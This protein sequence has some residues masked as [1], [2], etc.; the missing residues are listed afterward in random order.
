MARWRQGLID[1]GEDR[2]RPM[3]SSA[4]HPLNGIDF[5]EYTRTPGTRQ[6]T[7]TFVKARPAAPPLEKSHFSI[8][9]GIRVTG[10]EVESILL[11]AA[12][13]QQV[14]LMLSAEGDFSTY[15]VRVEHPE[16]DEQLSEASFGFKAACPSPF[17][18]RE[19]CNCG[20]VPAEEPALDYLARDYQ[21]FRRMLL[22]F[23]SARNPNWTERLPSDLGV[24]LVELFAY[25]GDYLSYFQD[26]AATEAYLDTALHRVSV[27]RHTRLIDYR[28]HDGGNAR[29]FVHLNCIAAGTVDAG[30]RMC[31][32]IDRPLVGSTG[33][34]GNVIRPDSGFSTD[35]AFSEVVLFE[36]ETDLAVLPEHNEL[37]IHTFGNA[38]CCIGAGTTELY[39]FHL[40]A[41]GRAVR[42]SLGPADLL[43]LEEVRSPRTGEPVDANPSNRWV[44]K[45]VE[46]SD[47]TDE[48]LTDL[49]A[50]RLNIADAALPLLR[51]EWSVSEA[52]PEAIQVSAVGSDLLPIDP[53]TVARGNIVAAD[54]GLTISLDSGRD[55]LG[56]PAEGGG[57]YPIAT[58]GVP[59]APV[60]HT[61]NGPAVELVL[62]F[63]GQEDETWSTVSDLLDSTPYDQHFVTE[64]DD[65]GTPNLRFGDDIYG[66]M[67][68]E[69]ERAQLTM[70]IGNG[71]AGNIGG[72]SLVHIAT[73]AGLVDA[74][75]QPLAAK[76]GTDPQP[77]AEVRR[78]APA[79]FRAEQ[80]RAVTEDDWRNAA[81][82]H[83]EVL[84][85]RA[86]FRWTGSWH[87]IFVAI[88][89][90]DSRNLLPTAGGGFALEVGFARRIH[91]HL[92]RFKLAGYDLATRSAV[93]VPIEIAATLCVARG[94]FPG[95]VMAAVR[96][97]LEGFFDQ[98]H[99]AFGR[100]V[101]LSQI[102]AAIRPIEG[103]ES[104]T[105]TTF[106][107]YWEPD[108][109][110][111][112]R[113][114]IDIDAFEI[115]RLDNNPSAPE[116]GVLILETA[117][118]R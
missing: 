67:P 51:V 34:P 45:L 85:A 93:Y 39:L 21:S 20:A 110:S 36:T 58:L 33:L 53:V 115:A 17:D 52:L 66:R 80:F 74:I 30:T 54:H 113:G 22:D 18:C 71:V 38:E 25:A 117:G 89:P 46:T 4:A 13:P 100:P 118:A 82:R 9:G 107:R 70:R 12:A 83:P 99:A 41:D 1:C 65:D 111:L 6:L 76:G 86:I 7:I 42:P 8:S 32:R 24:T 109:G 87:T 10:I 63:A 84:D 61:A 15:V 44:V 112:D 23:V 90:R 3:L 98:D 104:A 108:R 94:Y 19:D 79:A 97:V 49:L 78:L 57:R 81:L 101:Y 64:V 75:Y 59:A 2:R 88:H 48:A 14:T 103:L 56:L 69:A 47:T 37:R 27:K 102:Y 91:D 72:S 106:K 116:F 60:T 35:P 5:V 92:R 95:D 43:L 68:R 11:P 73:T 31:T 77:I 26:A 40:A 28:M 55:E 16:V 96:D 62:S 29:T 50:P 105:V 114:V